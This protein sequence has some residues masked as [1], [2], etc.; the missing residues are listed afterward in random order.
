MK[1]FGIIVIIF[2]YLS[3]N[4]VQSQNPG[5]YKFQKISVEKGLSHSV[6]TAI[7]QDK[8]GFMWFATQD[9]LNRFDGYNFVNFYNQKN[10]PHSLSNNFIQSVL[11]DN[12]NEIWVAT[13][14]GLCKFD[15][16]SER[17]TVF[18]HDSS[19]LNSIGENE[20]NCL[21]LAAN[22]NVWIGTS[23]RG[24][25]YYNKK[26]KVFSKFTGLISNSITAIFE[27]NDSVLWIGTYDIG[28]ESVDLRTNKHYHFG[29]SPGNYS[30]LQTNYIRCIAQD[31]LGNIWV[32]TN[33]GL[34]R[35]LKNSK[36]FQ[37]FTFD[38]QAPGSINGNIIRAIM[39]DSKKNL[40]VGTEEN[41]LNILNISDIDNTPNLHFQ[42]IQMSE[43]EFG[44]SIRSVNS[45]FLDRDK[46]IW[47]GTYSGGINFISSLTEKFQKYQ[48]NPY[49]NSTINYPKVW[50][51]C[52][53]KSGNIWVGTDGAG[54]DRLNPKTNSIKHFTHK[55]G[56]FSTISDNAIL[57]AFRD[58]NNT[59]W[60]GTY[61]GGLN[62]YM[63]KTETFKSYRQNAKSKSIPV[64]DVRVIYEDKNNTLWIGTNGGGLCTFNRQ[65]DNFSVLD[66]S[67]SDKIGRAHV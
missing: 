48:H 21:A 31:S 39:C 33:K 63:D 53:D 67:N 8:L 3:V 46:N 61:A 15:Y 13:L 62:Q 41:G 14:D 4:I 19:N 49:D 55:K 26:T 25:N 16:S 44:L 20:L 57:C 9:G 58:H 59:L 10:N 7:A 47:I 30:C 11:C 51:I 5:K 38:P 50:G 65:N 40:W 42:H 28:L 12:D 22:G 35:F 2:S 34:A 56:D 17:F 66:T 52:E 6:V 36:T 18:Y 37:V 60:F 45:M 24:L 29:A 27:D 23:H 54:L 1:R 43:N 32:G 64:N